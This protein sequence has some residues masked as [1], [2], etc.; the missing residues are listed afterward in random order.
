MLTL[1]QILKAARLMSQV[2]DPRPGYLRDDDSNLTGPTTTQRLST[3]SP[4]ASNGGGENDISVVYEKDPN[5]GEVFVV[6]HI[7]NS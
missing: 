2:G 4:Q 5:T 1:E 7:K 6:Q 3:N